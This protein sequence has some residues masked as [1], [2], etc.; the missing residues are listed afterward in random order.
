MSFYEELRRYDW[1]EVGKFIYTR[2]E[3]DVKRGLEKEKLDIEDFCALLSPAAEQYLEDMAIKA[4]EVTK[5][6]F[7]KTIKIYIP[8]YV[9]NECV[10]SCL[11]CGFSMKN[12]FHRKTLSMDEVK[13]ELEVIK[14]TGIKHLLVCSGEHPKKVSLGYLKRIVS[15]VKKDFSS[16][17]IE[18][19]PLDE[20]DYRI[21]YE[22]GADT[23]A[24]YQE[25]YNIVTYDEVHPA[26]KKRDFEYRLLSPERAAN[27]GFRSVGI[28]ALMG[29]AD[30]R[31][32]EFFVGLH[33]N[34]LMKKFWKTHITVSFPRIR[35]AEGDFKPKYTVTDK[36]L[37]QSML[38]LRLFL[39]DVGLVIS[40]REPAHFRDRLM[41]LGA[42]QMSAGSRT[43]PGGYASGETEG[44]QFDVEDTRS[45]E[46][47]IEAVKKNG[48]E[49]VLK[50]WDSGF[51]AAI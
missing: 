12:K 28:G 13:R 35:H 51:M 33:A 49:P 26:G 46:E 50:D 5:R 7:G 47:F 29:L 19:Q 11:Y 14:K 3:V 25:T 8:M 6:R 24:V 23:L 22:E 9:S 27:A 36:N 38:A 2:S 45:A 43:N 17:I 20:D 4:H 37:V 34:Y 42:T 15:E 10:N 40:T 32:D 21:L 31:I 44:K 16:V 18:V 41:K 1:D 48:F 39:N 30:F